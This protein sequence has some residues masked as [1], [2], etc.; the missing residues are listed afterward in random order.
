MELG[1]RDRF[2]GGHRKSVADYVQP[3]TY[4]KSRM[5]QTGLQN[6]RKPRY[7]AVCL[8]A[9]M[10]ECWVQIRYTGNLLLIDAVFANIF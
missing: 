7:R 9:L 3:E 4:R 5:C 1:T 10:P 8:N 6:K 2:G